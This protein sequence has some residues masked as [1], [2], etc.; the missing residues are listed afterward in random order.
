M[1][2][3]PTPPGTGV[4]KLHFFETSSKATS[5]LSLKPDL[6]LVGVLQLDDL[7][8][9]FTNSFIV[10]Q[11]GMIKTIRRKIKTGSGRYFKY[12]FKNIIPTSKTLDVTSDWEKTSTSMINDFDRWQKIRF[13]TLNDSVQSLF[14]SGDLGPSLLNYYI[15]YPDRVTIF[16]S[17][18]HPATQFAIQEMNKD[19]EEMKDFCYENNS[20]LIFINI[21]MNYF[22]GHEVIRTPSDV[23][24][25]YFEDN[26]N[27]DSIYQ[28][29]ATTNN[30][31]YIELTNH[32][33]G[34]Q[35]KYDYLF[36]YDGHPNKKGYEEIGNYIGKQLIEGSH[37]LKKE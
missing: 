20:K 21:P 22:T 36:K 17:P 18:N 34:L 29:V 8:Q 19:F 28:S 30:L 5:P 9:L 37:L 2:I 23:L 1:V 15:N 16:N 24:N 10:N 4:I 31:P 35:N 13:S 27:I 3:G 12:S 32:F 11:S 6:V 26:N 33:I 14:K 25:T 7:A